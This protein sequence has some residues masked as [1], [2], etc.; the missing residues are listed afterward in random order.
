MIYRFIYVVRSALFVAVR[1]WL[2]IQNY[3]YSKALDDKIN[4][5]DWSKIHAE[6]CGYYVVVDGM[7]LW[8][9]NHPYAS[10]KVGERLPKRRTR[11]LLMR[12]VKKHLEKLNHRN[13]A[14]AIDES[15]VK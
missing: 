2:W 14:K 13:I 12:E 3:K 9:K 7:R 15:M 10:F 1:P 11:V 5:L 6:D 4:S 8:C